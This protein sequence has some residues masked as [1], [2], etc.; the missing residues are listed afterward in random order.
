[1]GLGGLVAGGGALLGTGAFTTVEAER[2]VTVNAAGDA[3][4]LLALAQ[5]GDGSTSNVV[6]ETDGL[7]VI[8]FD[9][10]ASGSQGVNLDALTTVGV[11]SENSG[12]V[13]GVT[14]EALTITNNGTQTIDVGFDINFNAAQSSLISAST[15]PSD[16]L[17][18][19]TQNVASSSFEGNLVANDVTGLGSG[20][21]LN[22]AL[23]IDTVGLNTT[24][25]DDINSPL[26]ESEATI[27]ATSQ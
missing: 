10:A 11:V 21:T 24:D 22:V 15:T 19:W 3:S 6:Q 13:D 25:I 9:A 7:L 1:M 18:L 12:T 4:A 8:N 2:T 20:D 14:T 26:F 16:V 23:Q 27:T 5:S 17:K